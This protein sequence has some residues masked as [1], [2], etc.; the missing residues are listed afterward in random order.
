MIEQ[1][2]DNVIMWNIG[3]WCS[4]SQYMV[5][6]SLSGAALKSRYECVLSYV[7]TFSG[8]TLDVASKWN[9]KQT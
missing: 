7:D 5:E 4:V 6:W 2:Q 9:N 8:M 3:L 1:C